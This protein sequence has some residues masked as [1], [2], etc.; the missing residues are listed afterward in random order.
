M[1]LLLLCLLKATLH[2]GSSCCA[3]VPDDLLPFSGESTAGGPQESTPPTGRLQELTQGALHTLD[4]ASSDDERSQGSRLQRPTSESSSETAARQFPAPPRTVSP[5]SS[6]PVN[7]EQDDVIVG[8][9]LVHP[10][11]PSIMRSTDATPDPQSPIPRND[12]REFVLP[13][14]TMLVGNRRMP[15][16]RGRSQDFY[17]SSRRVLEQHR[18][19][20]NGVP[21]Q[22]SL[23]SPSPVHPDE[24]S[25]GTTHTLQLNMAHPVVDSD[26]ESSIG[27][28]HTL[29]LG[30]VELDFASE[31]GLWRNR[32][33]HEHVGSMVY[34][35][36]ENLEHSLDEVWS[37][38]GSREHV[39]SLNSI[40]NSDHPSP[41]PGFANGWQESS[42]ASFSDDESSTTAD[43]IDLYEN[44]RRMRHVSQPAPAIFH[45]PD[46][47]SGSNVI[48]DQSNLVSPRWMREQADNY[49]PPRWMQE[50]ADNSSPPRWMQ[51]QA[52]TQ[53]VE[54]HLP[55]SVG[56]GEF[57]E[58][59]E[60]DSALYT[61]E[62]LAVPDQEISNL[63]E[64]KV[65]QFREALQIR[66]HVVDVMSFHNI[67]REDVLSSDLISAFMNPAMVSQMKRS[68]L[69]FNFD[70]EHGCDRSG[71][72]REFYRLAAQQA[73]ERKMLL[74]TPNKDT[75]E[76]PKMPSPDL[77]RALG[78]LVAMAVLNGHPFPVYFSLPICKLL[79]GDHVFEVLEEFNSVDSDMYKQL[80]K[81]SKDTVAEQELTFSAPDGPIYQERD[82]RPSFS[83]IGQGIDPDTLV[84]E[85]NLEEY[86]GYIANL[87]TNNSRLRTQWRLFGQNAQTLEAFQEGFHHVLSAGDLRDFSPSELQILIGGV[88]YIDVPEWKSHTSYQTRQPNGSAIP[89]NPELAL[90]FWQYVDNLDQEKLAR[91]FEFLTGSKRMPA[92]GFT[93]LF[94]EGFWILFTNDPAVYPSVHTCIG[95]L[96]L[97]RYRSFEELERKFDIALS[98]PLN[99]DFA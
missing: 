48:T 80:S 59:W 88:S 28:T 97:P 75:Y 4:I 57:V 34:I 71:P 94:P 62:L 84:D 25:I 15:F 16:S 45:Q 11:S 12:N 54:T 44:R 5:V 85:N 32:G 55:V 96:Y 38:Q 39:G 37:T 98:Q 67:R 52:D 81:L 95:W 43:S 13:P 78:S 9:S 66:W 87:L 18:S 40:E 30:M 42:Q 53:I 58:D 19:R 47:P 10:G 82:S 91:L 41:Q 20:R 64:D 56:E 14:R 27:S 33:S 60:S 74:L 77:A 29:D 68:E 6:R 69:E 17:Q 24:S 7:D 63:Y 70:G 35:A 26:D 65:K 50:Q 99:F 90:H 1:K 21:D 83:S 51:E 3:T 8:S 76:L 89:A 23:D 22:P 61:Q 92:G 72:S 31:D 86:L 46:Y 2:A 79:L 36:R 93:N 49:S 73:V